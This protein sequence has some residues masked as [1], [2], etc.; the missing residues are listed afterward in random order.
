MPECSCNKIGSGLKRGKFMKGKLRIAGLFLILI[1]CGGCSTTAR[2]NWAAI[3]QGASGAANT[4]IN[5]YQYNQLQNQQFQQQQ[6]IWN[7]QHP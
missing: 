5:N 6:E 3:L 7:L 4:S 2:Q 1:C